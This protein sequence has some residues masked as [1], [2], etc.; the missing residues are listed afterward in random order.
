MPLKDVNQYTCY[1]DVE[2][3]YQYPFIEHYKL[4]DQKYP[5]SLFILNT[6]KKEN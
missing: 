5:N 2:Y 3:N 1:T 4:L 6:R